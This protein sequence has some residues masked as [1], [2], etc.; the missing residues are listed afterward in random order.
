VKDQGRL[1]R[2]HGQLVR[3]ICQVG[4]KGRLRFE[5]SQ[6]GARKLALAETAAAAG[7]LGVIVFGMGG[8]GIVGGR[9]GGGG[10]GGRSSGI[11][12]SGRGTIGAPAGLPGRSAE[13]ATI[14]A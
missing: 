7:G 9:A 14:A 1:L 8:L 4:V 2:D 5:R 13:G 6:R 10:E 11:P 3:Q 12:S